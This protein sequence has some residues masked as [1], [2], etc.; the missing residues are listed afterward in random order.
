MPRVSQ[1]TIKKL[2]AFIDSLPEAARSKC[3]L[4]SETLTHIT[5]MAEVETGAG[6]ATVTRVLANRINKDVSE[7]KYTI[8]SSR[9]G[10]ESYI[11][12][13]SIVIYPSLVKIGKTTHSVHHRIEQLGNILLHD[14]NLVSAYK[15]DPS[16]N[17]WELEKAIHS[18][19]KQYQV[20]KTREWFFESCLPIFYLTMDDLKGATRHG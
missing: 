7:G 3:A 20:D 10:G 17:L 18:V 8:P 9:G 12:V 4:C 16:I 11:Y 5:K 15:I 1:D 2:N 13:A 6:T 19:L 14:F